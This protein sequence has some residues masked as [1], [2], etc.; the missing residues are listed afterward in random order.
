MDVFSVYIPRDCGPVRNVIWCV[1]D[2][3]AAPAPGPSSAWRGALSCRTGSRPPSQRGGAPTAALCAHPH[4]QRQRGLLVLPDPGQWSQTIVI[5]MV[6]GRVTRPGLCR[7]CSCSASGAH[8]ASRMASLMSTQVAPGECPV[9]SC[10]PASSLRSQCQAA[11]C[12]TTVAPGSD[13]SSVNALMARPCCL[14]GTR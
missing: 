5:V 3:A 7:H 8:T 14:H 6:I 4:L 13:M 9:H 10:A 2:P 11:C 1:T 12:R